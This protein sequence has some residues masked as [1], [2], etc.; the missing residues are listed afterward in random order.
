MTRDLNEDTLTEETL[1]RMGGAR[2][3]RVRQVSEA[4]VRH[5]HALIRETEPT[6]AEWTAA[7]EFL[8]RAGRM[9]DDKRQEFVLLSDTLG[10]SMLVSVAASLF[11]SMKQP[12]YL[13]TRHAGPTA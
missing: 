6:Q 13:S 3:P 11:A 8:T 9:C 2:D 4:L 7:I 12:S 10:A 5:L 1:A